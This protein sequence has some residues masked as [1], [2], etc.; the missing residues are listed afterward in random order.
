MARKKKQPPAP[1]AAP[2][3]PAGGYDEVSIRSWGYQLQKLNLKKAADSP[4]DLLVIDYSKDGSDEKALKPSDVAALQ[5]KPDGGRRVVLSYLSIGEAESYRY[6][7]E[8]AWKKS[9]PAW[10]LGENPDW[11]ENYAV[12]FWDPGW[13]EK[14]CG[15]PEAYLDK[16]IDAGFDGVYLDKCDV[17]EDMQRSFKAVAKSRRDIAG[18]M[19]AFVARLSAYAKQRRPGF[20]V[21]MQNAESLLDRKALVAAIDGVA[22]EELVFGQDGPEKHNMHDDVEYS[23]AQLAKARD[24]GKLVLVVEY[25]NEQGKIADAAK[26]SAEQ[27]FV[28]YVSPKNRNL[29]RL[30]YEALVA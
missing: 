29:D 16:I 10:M 8:E 2:A 13:Q 20:L 25:L 28:L 5:R 18:D 17:F 27:G 4:F 9:P 6:Y 14:I 19:V 7:W 15:T 23:T 3:A 12:C 26:V 22:K 1:A 24:A 11:E 30:N 21:V